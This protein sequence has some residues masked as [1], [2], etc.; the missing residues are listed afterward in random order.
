M[1]NPGL[2]FIYLKADIILAAISEKEH[3]ALAAKADIPRGGVRQK[4]HSKKKK[5]LELDHCSR[6]VWNVKSCDH[7]SHLKRGSEKFTTWSY[8]FYR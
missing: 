8:L 7:R 2:I 3:S 1:S 5:R 6:E 4:R